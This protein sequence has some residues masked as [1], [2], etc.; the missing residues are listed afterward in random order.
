MKRFLILM[1]AAVIGFSNS[2][3]SHAAVKAGQGCSKLGATSVV[4]SKK[5]TCVKV[6][7]KLIWNSGVTNKKAS[8]SNNASTGATGTKPQASVSVTDQSLGQGCNGYEGLSATTPTGKVLKCVR[9][10]DGNIHWVGPSGETSQPE[11]NSQNSSGTQS[12]STQVF[13]TVTKI[14]SVD[15]CKISDQRTAKFQ[16]NNVGFPMTQ[17]EISYLG[18]VKVAVI[19]VDFAD[20]VGAGNPRSKIDPLLSKMNQWAEQFSNG[21]MT[22]E[23]QTTDSWIRSPKPSADLAFQKAQIGAN[24]PSTATQNEYSQAFINATSDKFNFSGVTAIIYYFPPSVQGIEYDFGQRNQT[25]QTKQGPIRVMYWGGGKYHYSNIGRVNGE[26]KQSLFWAFW[27][28]EILHSQGFPLHAP[29]NGFIT[30]LAT[31]Q[32]GESGSFDTWSTFKA[33]WLNDNQ[34]VCVDKPNLTSS[35]VKLASVDRNGAGIKSAMVKISEHEVLVVESRKNVDWSSSWP[36]DA[37]GL[38]VYKVDTK[39]DNDRTGESTGD[40][41]NEPRYS[42]W[43]YFLAPDGVKLEGNQSRDF[44]NYLIREGRT[45]TDSGVKITLVKLGDEDVIQIQ[46]TS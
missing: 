45:L 43:A 20:A 39:K 27:I 9:E 46:K 16:P 30:G 13:P 44:K 26:T 8:T 31:D 1:L 21:K 34:V 6:N 14:D 12:G 35:F 25:M 40:T 37:N 41:G 29:G 32:Y 28:H 24:D 15:V 36:S 10:A 3:V 42:K 22:F 11:S 5:F 17:G 38:L 19:P 23:F 33:G 2:P 4:G 18:K 7:K